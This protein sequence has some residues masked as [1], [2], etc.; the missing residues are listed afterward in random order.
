M[1]VPMKVEDVKRINLDALKWE[2][3]ALVSL[4]ED[5]HR[6]LASWDESLCERLQRLNEI[7]S[8]A[9]D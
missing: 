1:A 9:F 7:I 3:E 8:Q 4:L 2:A 6:G 5:R